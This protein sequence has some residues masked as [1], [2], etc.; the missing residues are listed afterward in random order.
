MADLSSEVESSMTRISEL[1][2]AMKEYS[3]MDRAASQ[4]IDIHKGLESTLKIFSPKLKDIE[5]VRDYDRALPQIRAYAGELNQVWTNLIDN[6][7]DAMGGKGRL[8]IRTSA[9][10]DG[11]TVEIGDTGPGIPAEVKSRIFDPFFTTKPVGRGTGLGL[12]ITYRI[13]TTRHHGTIRV[14]SVP[15]NTR[16]EVHLPQKQTKEQK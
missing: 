14:Y 5:V 12:D 10:D 13:I 16:F 7:I 3:Y 15:G 2:G 11:V 8:T 1:V 6:A 9:D 4:E